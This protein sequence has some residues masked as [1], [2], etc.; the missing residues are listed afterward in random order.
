MSSKLVDLLQGAFTFF[1]NRMFLIA[2]CF[3]KLHGLFSRTWLPCYCLER[4]FESDQG[5]FET[6]AV[7]LM[8]WCCLLAFLVILIFYMSVQPVLENSLKKESF[9][10]ASSNVIVAL[11]CCLSIKYFMTPGG[12]CRV[13]QPEIP[14]TPCYF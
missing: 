12:M 10:L 9:F 5:S 11:K 7:V 1:K 6:F 14:A 3:N 13:L 8:D 2:N 4:Q